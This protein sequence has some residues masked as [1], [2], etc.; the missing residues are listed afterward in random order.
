MIWDDKK[1]T[2][3]INDIKNK[4]ISSLIFNTN[5]KSFNSLPSYQNIKAVVLPYKNFNST[6]RVPLVIFEALSAEC[7]VFLPKWIKEDKEVLKLINEFQNINKK[8]EKNLFFYDKRDDLIN[9]LNQEL[10][11][12]SEK[13]Y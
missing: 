11:N 2:Q 12:I 6:I 13:I 8:E 7:L 5:F 1:D 9:L 10:V 3:I 4:N